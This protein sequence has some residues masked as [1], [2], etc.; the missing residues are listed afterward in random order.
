MLITMVVALYTSR[1]V[2]ETLG[3]TDFGIYN[4]VGGIV[5]MMGFL[6]N[7]MASASQRFLS[8]EI[9]QKN[10][11]K[12]KKTF[13]MT[14]TI[15]LIFALIIFIITETIGLW[16]IYNKLNIPQNRMSA[17]LW[18]YQFS[19]FSFVFSILRI[20]YNALIIAHEKMQFYAW[21][22]IIEVILKLLI[23]FMLVWFSLD[24]LVL[25]SIL[26]FLVILIVS[27]IYFIYC[28]INFRETNYIFIW[29]KT[30]FTSMFGFAGWNLFDSIANVAKNEGV[31]ILLNIF[32][33]PAIN[34]ARGISFQVSNQ[35]MGFV[36]NL[37]MAA[38][39]QI[40]KYYAADQKEE[41]KKL[42]FESSKYSY[43]L[44]FLVTLPVYL[45][46]DLLLVWWLKE[47]PNYTQVFLELILINRLVDSL[48]G[49][50]N[51]L[52]QATGRMKIYQIFSGI[53]ILLN[54]PV[55]YLFLYFGY[56]PETTI[57]VSIAISFI[58]VYGRIRIMNHLTEIN[59]TD[60]LTYVIK[61]NILVS[62]FS[63]II[64][65]ILYIKLEH[66]ILSFFIIGS[67][68][69]LSTLVLIY[70]IGLKNTDRE[71]ILFLIRKR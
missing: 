25:Y 26:T 10:D 51:I 38:A 67:A 36:G 21:N 7:S 16:F 44:L 55:S 4:V 59:F 23:V 9:G 71:K 6:T 50:T 53:V 52:V 11:E 66:N 35:M 40:I 65:C 1:V 69:V 24:K 60:Y 54:L 14:I 42:Y 68:S 62:F 3:V 37:Q 15:Y 12:L 47:V 20:P 31:N 17:V 41:M 29:D 49:T 2:L 64:P 45:N 18:V 32:F 33:N 63:V 22:T 48:A 5:S 43:F 61:P 70:Y 27:F 46:L 39:P 19:I 34:A 57:I 8:F 13:S 58:I 56:K 30:L 28:K